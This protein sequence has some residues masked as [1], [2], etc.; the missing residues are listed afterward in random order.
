MPE[1][2]PDVVKLPVK[3]IAEYWKA[4]PMNTKKK[5]LRQNVQVLRDENGQAYVMTTS[6]NPIYRAWLTRKKDS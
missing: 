3:A 4:S 5:L 6:G 1:T 2:L